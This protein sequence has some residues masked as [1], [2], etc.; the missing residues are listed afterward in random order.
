MTLLFR[1][2]FFSLPYQIQLVLFVLNLLQSSLTWQLFHYFLAAKGLEPPSS[3][4]A[5]QNTIVLQ[6]LPPKSFL[7][8][9]LCTKKLK[10]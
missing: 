10:R 7:V 3:S 1:L 5:L 9:S 6:T 8:I 2:P 4:T